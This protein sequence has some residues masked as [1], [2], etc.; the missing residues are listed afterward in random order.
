MKNN[1]RQLCGKA[2]INFAVKKKTWLRV[3]EQATAFQY[4]QLKRMGQFNQAAAGKKKKIHEEL[5]IFMS[6]ESRD[7]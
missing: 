7:P 1:D 3:S 4:Q 2:Q 6:L 5:S